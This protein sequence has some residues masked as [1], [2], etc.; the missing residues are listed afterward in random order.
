MRMVKVVLTHE[1]LLKQFGLDK[2][3]DLVVTNIQCKEGT[4]FV[5]Y[6]TSPKLPTVPEGNEPTQMTLDTVRGH[7]RS[8]L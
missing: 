8:L 6:F 1:D 2:H 7:G 4:L 3:K 5:F